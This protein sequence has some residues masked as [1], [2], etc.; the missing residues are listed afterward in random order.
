MKES[1]CIGRGRMS[2]AVDARVSAC[3]PA[4]KALQG[5]HALLSG[6][7]VS[8]GRP[9]PWHQGCCE[10]RVWCSLSI[11]S[12]SGITAGASLGQLQSRRWCSAGGGSAL[13]LRLMT[14]LAATGQGESSFPWGLQLRRWD[15]EIHCLNLVR[16]W[17]GSLRR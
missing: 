16:I 5:W 9:W 17:S 14:E 13:E 4:L 15:D 8:W 2:G 3:N 7:R 6:C 10:N 1:I 12:Q 11:W